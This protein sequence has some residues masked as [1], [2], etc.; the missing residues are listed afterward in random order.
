MMKIK[1]A[2]LLVCA[3]MVCWQIHLAAGEKEGYIFT[4]TSI[5][6]GLSESIVNAIIQDKQGF[7]WFGTQDGLNKF[8]GYGF[9]VY[10]AQPG[11]TTSLSTNYIIT[12]YLDHS[13][14]IWIG[15]AGGGLNKFDP[16]TEQF[17]CYRHNPKDSSSISND[18]IVTICENQQGN[19]WIGTAGGGLNLFNRADETFMRY[20]KDPHNDFSLSYNYI[21]ALYCDRSGTLWIGTLGGGLNKLVQPRASS[22]P[23]FMHYRHNPAVA[24]TISSDHISKIV[25]DKAEHLW[26]GTYD[27]GLNR[28]DAAALQSGQIPDFQHFNSKTGLSQDII[29]A[30][31]IDK[32]NRVW[33]GTENG[34]L[35]IL[36][37]RSKCAIYRHDPRNEHSLSNDHICSI[38]ED[39]SGIVW[40]GTFGG[41]FN[42]VD[43]YRKN[44][45]HYYRNPH[46][47][48]SLNNN[49][50]WALWE[51]DPGI[52][53]VGTNGG[54]LNRIDRINDRVT[55]Y[56]SDKNNAHSISSDIV[57]C[58]YRDKQDCLWIGTDGGGLNQLLSENPPIFKRFMADTATREGIGNN[59]INAI[60]S[61]RQDALWIGTNFGVTKMVH[62]R[63][64]GEPMVFKR[65][66]HTPDNPYSLNN[67]Q[68]SALYE[69]REGA[70]WV[71]TQGGGLNK[72][73]S[74]ADGTF[75]HFTYNPSDPTSIS[76]NF[77]LTIFQDH[78]GDIWIGTFG[79]GL[80]KLITDQSGQDQAKFKRYTMADGL[81]N[82]VVYAIQEDSQGD[83]WL[84]TNY[85]LSKFDPL[86][87]TIKNYTR[88]DGLQSNEFNTQASFKSTAG[89]L[90]FGGINGITAFFPNDITDYPHAPYVVLTDFKLFNRSVPINQLFHGRT[91]LTRSITMTDKV[92]LAHNENVFSIEFAALAYH[93]PEKNRYQYKLEGF[94]AAWT[95]TDASKR[96]A[97]YTNLDAGEYIFKVK[98]ANSDGIWNET[99]KSL[100]IIVTPPFWQAFWFRSFIV[101][102]VVGT[103]YSWNRRRMSKLEKRRQELE[104]QVKEKTEAAQ[105]LSAAYEQVEQLKNQLHAENIYLQSEIKL[106]HNFCQIITHSDK[107]KEIL[108]QVEQV[109]AT[110]A[111]VLIT[112]ESG[113]GKELLARAIHCISPRKD[114]ALVK[115]DC[116]ALP[117]NLIESEL[118]GHE[119]GAFTGAIG[120]KIGR[121]E[122]ANQGTI[123]LDEIGEVPLDLQ[124]KLL[125][126]LQDGEFERLGNTKTIKVDVRIIAATNR[127][128]EAEIEKGRFREDLYYRLNV[129]PII[130][131]PLRERKEDIALLVNYFIKKYNAKL[132][133]KIAS[134]SQDV[135]TKLE[136]YHWPGNVRELENIIER[137]IIISKGEN[138]VI[139]DWLPKNGMP[140]GSNQLI[141]LEQQER[142][143]I[144]KALDL[145]NWRVSGEKGAA[146]LLDINPQTLVSR[147][148]KLGIVKKA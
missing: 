117:P 65:F 112:G 140:A 3:V 32:D 135:V 95:T 48:N 9:K 86:N 68:I 59:Y 74:E 82:D 139:G 113:T 130:I 120:Q 102:T 2:A 40:I 84:S 143:H 50:V 18:W 69:D 141:S 138:L 134:V 20:K 51:D 33:V 7:L 80:N 126:L 145:T 66:I 52:L 22:A 96:F 8:D 91:I 146:H 54:G 14:L 111:T 133:K 57:R 97:T 71:G 27:N 28:V 42:K 89:E 67:N 122:L 92:K 72:L 124:T 19:L 37:S 108:G 106:Q 45:N 98:A 103:A 123:F 78:K 16:A 118:F 11:D 142:Q 44:F 25:Q 47:S 104:E 13:G 128:L 26:I 136:N 12:L 24:T 31:F 76:S 62:P 17:T 137:S 34:G 1:K 21:S 94:D 73:H 83:L 30:L 129:F 46:N 115:V 4:R 101:L 105:A 85:G 56:I 75:L 29:T 119:K 100:T 55:H 15:T 23:I 49:I 99:G 77:I 60:C 110:E 87:E 35:T 36:L 109:A 5:E 121:F 114:R 147:M 148:K 53:W 125:R 70:L 38:Y 64:A 116:G 61:S 58:L 93:V 39:Q 81:P 79:Y 132:G 6:H 90:F 107:L 10:K 43:T 127:K 41:G 63:K 88:G 131:P 144:I